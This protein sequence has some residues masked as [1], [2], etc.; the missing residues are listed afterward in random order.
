MNGGGSL[1]CVGVGMTLGAHLAARARRFIEQAQTVFVLVSDRLVEQWVRGM[2]ADVRSLQPLYAEGKS[3]HD[4]YREM[5][6][7]VMHEVRAGRH[8]CGAFYGHPG[9][10]AKVPHQLVASARTEGFDAHME[11]GVSAEDCLYADLGIDPGRVGCQH[12]E[13]TQF[14]VNQ[15][16][17]DPSA[18]LVLWQAAMVGDRSLRRY[19]T[20][21]AWRALLV[22]R[23]LRDYPADHAL[24]I[25]EA[26]T[27]AV[28]PP[29][30]EQ[31]RLDRLVDAELRLQSTLVIP[32]S[33]PV[34][35]D[36]VMLARLAE[37]ESATH[38]PSAPS[39][40]G[41]QPCPT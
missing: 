14:V 11:A 28:V 20:G 26:A 1:V 7:L 13:A 5:H 4:T 17:I 40:Q 2:N 23:L 31:V 8:V 25:Y 22:E 27:L 30:I 41:K 19:A 3:R 33:R 29:R 37:L 18:Y 32:P 16:L 24:T 12:H 10:F 34:R 6:A 21:A 15:R 9:V 36:P 38:L 39:L 35:P